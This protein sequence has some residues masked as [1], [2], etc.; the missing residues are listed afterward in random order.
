MY[1]SA[2]EVS[3]LEIFIQRWKKKKYTLD[4]RALKISF[5][6]VYWSIMIKLFHLI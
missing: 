5:E 1:R 4:N 6:K 2:L 3:T